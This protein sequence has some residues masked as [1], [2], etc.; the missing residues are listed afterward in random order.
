MPPALNAIEVTADHA[1]GQVGDLLLCVWRRQTTMAGVERMKAH[2]ASAQSRERFLV[3]VVEPGAQ[4]PAPE[5]RD[6][7]AAL[8]RD[9]LAGRAVASALVFE[10]SGVQAN[11]VRA[12]VM[13]L[14]LLARQRYPHRIFSTT[15]E[16]LAWLDRTAVER[17]TGF[18]SAGEA[19]SALA[20]LR[21]MP[22]RP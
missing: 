15:E 12:A 3:S 20:V 9:G 17:G 7:L 4:L 10:G 21:A 6:A 14:R 11:L 13:T 1:F 5:V 8:L 2:V 19:G 16:A 22:P 18:Q